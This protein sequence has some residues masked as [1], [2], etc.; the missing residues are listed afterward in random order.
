VPE[1]RVSVLAERAGV[2]A[3]VGDEP[4][5]H[6]VASY[7]RRWRQWQRF[8][9]H[10]GVGALP[11]DPLHVAAFV[12][13][14]ARAGVS[15]SGIAAN[16]SAIGWFHGRLDPPRSGVTET[17]RA[18][19]RS[20]E[21]QRPG[22]VVS[23][24]PV[25]SVGALAAMARVPVRQG[26]GRA[27]RLLRVLTGAAPRQ[28]ALVRA[29]DVV[30]GP[31]G[32]WVELRLPAVPPWARRP[33]IP[34]QLVRLWAGRSILDCPVEAAAALV[35][36]AAGGGLMDRQLL[37]KQ[38]DLWSEAS[39]V[40][41]RLAARN[42]ALVAVGYAGAL[43]VEELSTARVEHL[44]PVG[45]SY[46]LVLP[47]TKTSRNGRAEAVALTPDGAPFDAVRLLDRWLAVR[48]DHDGPL[49]HNVHH[50]T[51]LDRGMEPGEIRDTIRDL[52]VSVGVPA[53]VS[54][55]SLRRSWATHTYLRDRNAV[56]QI[57]LQLRH[58]RINTTVRYIEDLACHLLNANEFLSPEVVAAGPGGMPAPAKNLGFA[59]EAL[60]HLVTE[61]VGLLQPSA[62]HAPATVRTITSHWQRWEAWA[63]DHGIRAFPADPAHVLLF[64]AARADEG[65]AANTLRATVR[66]IQQ[67]HDE[68]GVPTVGFVRLA[69]DVI[70]G[71]ERSRPAPRRRAPVLP[72]GD[73]QRMAA[74]ARWAGENGELAG[75]RDWVMVAVG[76]TGGLRPGDLHQARLEDL[77]AS[78]AGLVLHLAGQT[79]GAVL[80]VP[81][82]DALDV[83]AALEAWRAATGLH[84]GPLLPVVPLCQPSRP[85]SKETIV[86][87]LARLAARS[88]SGV[89]PTGDSLRRSWAT[90]AYEAGVDLLSINRHLR[91]RHFDVRRGLTATLS[92]WPDNPAGRLERGGQGA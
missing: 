61:A 27:A 34:E 32:A 56:G 40:P 35:T 47:R 72:I 22:R 50:H 45:D 63:A 7:E 31:G 84:A 3:G 29:G 55:Y 36:D 53:T 51:D 26:R 83:G 9:G 78:S 58:G 90:H 14:R 71:T 87:R 8:A 81:R 69:G 15:P 39:T 48:G 37:Y 19:L 60:E 30:F 82:H 54:G 57:S 23:P 28:L 42:R 79:A 62:R 70:A 88:G 80:L 68:A 92:P 46:R 89:R 4:S 2:L 16:L 52:A 67:V 77:H 76:Y 44:E 18:V 75:L 73:L 25:L 91:R 66:A 20:V 85:I 6:T 5:R 64:A 38:M 74:F 41:L 13:A 12:V 59:T 49:F 43:R 86:D 1:S 21:R 24:A 17:A 65:A 33:A 10:H 11:A